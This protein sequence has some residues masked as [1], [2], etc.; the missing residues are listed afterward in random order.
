MVLWKATVVLVA[1][2]L[3]GSGIVAF[4]RSGPALEPVAFT[5]EAPSSDGLTA[6]VALANDSFEQGYVHARFCA[7]RP[8][9]MFSRVSR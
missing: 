6:S 3:T 2:G 5:R 8:F 9:A 1:G 4:T 7:Q